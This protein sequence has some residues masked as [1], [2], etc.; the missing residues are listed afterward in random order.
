MTKVIADYLQGRAF[1]GRQSEQLERIWDALDSFVL[2]GAGITVTRNT[3][4]GAV[5][6]AATFSAADV[7]T[8][9]GTAAEALTAGRF[10]NLN[11]S[12][13]V[14]HADASSTSKLA[15]GFVLSSYASGATNVLVYYGDENT[16]LSGLTSGDTY[17]LSTAGQ[18]TSTPPTTANYVVQQLGTARNATT[19]LVNLQ[20]GIQRPAS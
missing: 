11:A 9:T 14:Q 12:G 4:T 7:L 8:F 1:D 5:T 2:A 18:V 13:A 20:Q 15:H 6:I 16:A 10:V 19:L 3:D 17:Y